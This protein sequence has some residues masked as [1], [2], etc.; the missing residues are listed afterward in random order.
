LPAPGKIVDTP[1]SSPREGAR[2][3]EPVANE[4]GAASDRGGDATWS[5]DGDTLRLESDKDITWKSRRVEHWHIVVR[6]RGHDYELFLVG[7][8]WQL[9]Y[10]ERNAKDD[11][12]FMFLLQSLKREKTISAAETESLRKKLMKEKWQPD[13]YR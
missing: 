8:A 2:K 5:L 12:E 10:F 4:S 1:K 7:I 3:K 6:R 9:P 11:P 13:F